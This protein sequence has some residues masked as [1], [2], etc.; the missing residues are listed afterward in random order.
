MVTLPIAY[1]PSVAYMSC[2]LDA[3]TTVEAHEHY[4]KQTYRNRCAIAGASGIMELSVPV[5]NGANDQCP[6]RDVRIAEQDNWRHRHWH[7]IQSCYGASP[8]FEY[9]AP[10][11][12][13]MYR[14]EHL[15]QSAL[16]EYNKTLV[17]LLCS[18]IHLPYV[19]R[20]SDEYRGKNIIPLTGLLHPCPANLQLPPYYQVFRHRIGFVANLSV[21]DLL[22]NMGP[23]SLL[24]LQ[25]THR[26]VKKYLESI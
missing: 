17:Q 12:E 14:S 19:W 6:V 7:T 16:Y 3:E 4:Q 23:E 15:H 2:L 20:E 10:D 26:C 8:Y 11:L 21:F 22:F 5:L 18:L 25:E 1:A 24:V 9:Y 13:Y